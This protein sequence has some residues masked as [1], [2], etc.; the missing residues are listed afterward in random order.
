[1]LCLVYAK[2]HQKD[3]YC[4]EFVP[5]ALMNIDIDHYRY[6]NER[7]WECV[8]DHYLKNLRALGLT[9]YES[10]ILRSL[11]MRLDSTRFVIYTPLKWTIQF[12]NTPTLKS[13][14]WS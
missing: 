9:S 5:W 11:L 12:S 8:C 10:Y 13:C 14:L 1:V 3:G 4:N 7:N 2:G 6:N